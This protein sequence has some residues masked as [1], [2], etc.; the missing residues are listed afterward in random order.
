MKSLEQLTDSVF[1]IMSGFA[2]PRH[3]YA[4]MSIV[5]E[6]TGGQVTIGPAS[7]YTIIKKLINEQYITLYDD[8]DSRRK[9]YVLTKRGR[10]VLLQ[11]I[12]RRKTMVEFALNGL[13]GGK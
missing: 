4:V 11:D 1:Y 12:E 9:V 5:E 8:S 13:Q 2:Q 10:E 3:G 6:I 7:L